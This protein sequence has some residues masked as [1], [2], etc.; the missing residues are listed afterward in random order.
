M[1]MPKINIDSYN[2]FRCLN[3]QHN[4]YVENSGIKNFIIHLEVLKEN[5]MASLLSTTWL[6]SPQ[7][8]DFTPFTVTFSDNNQ[9]NITFTNGGSTVGTWSEGPNYR[10]FHLQF[11]WGS[12]GTHWNFLGIHQNAQG[13]GTGHIE[14]SGGVQVS[15]F[16][17]TK[18]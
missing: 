7:N 4:F 2:H 16:T 15:P 17:M 3:E 12:G 8:H 6:L 9:A 14:W 13:S 1:M 10:S 5:T 18:D 11:N